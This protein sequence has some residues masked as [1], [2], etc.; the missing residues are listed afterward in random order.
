MGQQPVGTKFL[1]LNYRIVF[2]NTELIRERCTTAR[3]IREM[4]RGCIFNKSS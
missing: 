1:Y 3:L 2:R 4:L